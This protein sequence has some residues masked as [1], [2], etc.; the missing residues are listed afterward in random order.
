MGI[1]HL[2]WKIAIL[3]LITTTPVL[4]QHTYRAVIK[5][6]N[7]GESLP[8]ADAIVKGT[9]IGSSAGKDGLIYLK[10]I[11]DGRQVLI[12]SFIGYQS[13][14]KTLVF[15]LKQSHL[16]TIQLESGETLETVVIRSFRN[17]NH[18]E[19]IPTHVQVLGLDEVKEE[20]NINPGNI[21]KLL[22]ETSGIRVQQTS[23]VSGNV[24]FR[25]QGLPGKY[26][27]LLQDGF[28]LY[29]GFS[30]G[31]SLLQIPPL[32]LQQVEV[33]RG[34]ASTLYGG[35]AIAGIVNL[36]TKHPEIKPEFKVLLNQTH[37]GGNDI[38]A[39]YAQKKGKL[40]I[41]LLASRNTQHSVDVSKNGFTDIPEYNRAVL[42][43]RLF[44]DFNT[45]NHIMIGL[46]SGYE[47]RTG[48]DIFA[49]RNHPDSSHPFYEENK[50]QRTNGILKF[51]STLQN[52]SVIT[53]K[54]N[55][56]SYNR[57][58]FTNTNSFGGRQITAYTE[59]T[60]LKNS[61]HHKWVTGFNILL[62]RF[63]QNKYTGLPV[64]DYHHLT[65]GFFTQDDW[66][67]S[68]RLTFEPGIRLDKHN[69]YGVFFLP[70]FA[71]MYKI[72]HNLMTRFSGGLG[73]EIPTPFSEYADHTRFQNV[74]SP[75]D[76]NAEKSS[77]LNMDIHFNK[78]L[79]E[80]LNISVNQ[81]FFSTQIINPVIVN[82]DS[83][84]VHTVFYE[85]APG[86]MISKG[87]NTNIRLSYGEAVLYIDYT[88]LDARKKYD[89]NLPLELSPK[90]RLT[91]TLAWEDEESG[92][93]MGL[94]AFYFGHQ[95]LENGD[96]TKDY[97][98]LGAMI[99]KTIGH[100]TIAANV[101]NILDVRQSRF[102][103]IVIPPLNNPSFKELYA[104][105]DG[106]LGNIVLMFHLL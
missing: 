26:T 14:Q 50:T 91:T 9:T 98:I 95:Y 39:W 65:L 61:N 32:N 80:D 34:S 15:P 18:I 25:I 55:I 45:N 52:G 30:S 12:F 43:P 74:L 59:G 60:Y 97:W 2:A 54:G 78:R 38:T 77:G 47:D 63:N 92:L 101:E 88:L 53:L 16:D 41:T 87:L 27:Q 85:N 56:S 66:K 68:D 48:G 99:Q 11:P 17:N 100:I 106:I 104:P 93:R 64:L 37:K 58:L 105:L 72:S 96:K 102:E 22:G 86:H 51:E 49:V 23:A 13:V 40:G 29:S 35:S 81:G 90:H 83:L 69:R 21:S 94:E 82:Q 71:M 89:H 42:E 1:K 62:D 33:I 31:L 79:G 103:D 57:G 20:T 3:V 36:I 6:K 75:T 19:E 7:S 8:G 84:Q 28:P 44:Y 46:S 70:R 5:D 4:G 10:D 67:I 76:L 24:S 73:Y